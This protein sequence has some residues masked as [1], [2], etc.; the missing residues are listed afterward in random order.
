MLLPRGYV[1]GLTRR[2]LFLGATTLAATFVPL[3]VPA[4]SSEPS[5]E[6]AQVRQGLHLSELPVHDPFVVAHEPT[7]TYWLYTSASPRET[8]ERRFGVMAYTSRD[9]VEWEGPHVVFEI[10]DGTWANPMHGAWA[11]EVHEYEGRFHLFVTLHNNDSIFAEPP[12]V[13][14]PNHLRGSVVAVAD[15]PGGPFELLKPEGPHP[16][17]HFMTLD[18]SLYVDPEGQPW[19]V[20]C[21]EWIQK[22]DGTIEAIRLTPDLSATVGEPIHLFKGSD[23]PWLNAAI[24]PNTDQLSYVT[25]GNQ[26]YRTKTGELL[27]LWS[28]YENGSYVETVARSESGRLEGPWVQL[29]PLVYQDSG[30]GMLFETFN[31]QLMMVLHRPFGYPESRAL[32]FEMEDTGDNLR[33]V[34]PRPDLHDPVAHTQQSPR[35]RLDFDDDWRF[36]LGDVAAASSPSYDDSD[37][38]T[39]DLPHDW[40]IEGPFSADHASGTGYL[41]GGVGWYRKTFTLPESAD[42]KHVA[43]QFDGVYQ[44]AEVWINGHRLGKRPY[45]YISF[46]HELTPHLRFGPDAS[47]VIAV[48]VD[49]SQVA[50]SRWYNGS[51]IYRHVWLDVTDAVRVA[52]WGTY[53]TTPEVHDDRARVRIET[54]LVNGTDDPREVV[55]ESIVLDPDGAVVGTTESTLTLAARGTRTASQ[56]LDLDGPRLWSVEQ[57]QLYTLE[58]HVRG[59][60]GQALDRYETPFGIRTVRFDPQQGFFLNG[61][62]MLIKGVCLHHD[63]GPLGAAVPVAEWEHRLE[64]MKEMGA[65]AIRTSHNPAAPELLDLADRMGFLVMEEA[66][67][68]FEHGKKKWIQGWNV[69]QDQGRAGEGTYYATHGYSDFFEEWAERDLRDMVRRDRNHASIVLW[70]IGNEVDYPNDPY[71]DPADEFYEEGRPSFDE[72]PGLVQMLYDVVKSVDPTRPVTMASAN[73]PVANEHG[74]ADILDVTGYNYQEDHYEEDH[75]RYPERAIIGSEN[76]D[77]YQAW[78]VVEDNPYVAGQFLWTGIDYLGEAGRFPARSNASGLVDLSTFRKPSFY[79]RKSLWSDEPVVHLAVVDPTDGG[80]RPGVASH[81]SWDVGDGEPVSVLAYSNVDSV[82]LSLD[83]QPLG[84]R[85]R[86][87]AEEGVLRWEVGYAPG[88]LRAVGYRDGEAVA[89]HSL[90][91]AR[92]PTR[93]VLDTDRQSLAADGDDVAHVRAYVVDAEGRVV[94]SAD[95]VIRFDV[96]GP[97]KNIGVG[98]GDHRSTESFQADRR[99]AL[100]GRALLFVQSTEEPGTIHVRASAEGLEG[101]E[102]TISNGRP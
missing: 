32:L 72:L 100:Q 31:G 51:G 6:P 59:D 67:D 7:G 11:P 96:S 98:S 69:G 79:F 86:A 90:A 65:N 52:Q 101:A 39:L 27:M 93:L 4:Q 20:Y 75:A 1:R 60:E 50:D 41:P 70:S 55:I 17:R 18:G 26:L 29:D 97:G 21:H 28:A 56:E 34:R 99:R 92:A 53:V 19:M 12:E 45:G 30:H 46:Y 85:T 36:H 76:N 94:P 77:A 13:W 78:R 40:S 2:R 35:E 24:T 73:I 58:T 89:S 84:T 15:A 37:W 63:A 10:P 91:T 82:S 66:F 49:H 43:I 88:T 62:H 14:R 48:R 102:L 33:V 74:Y 25:D 16:P 83:G 95:P 5:G 8:G 81:W 9:L 87:D 22:I 80:R 54:D 47:N 3:H 44:N 61:E 23:A 38:R 64:L 42:G 68:E 71:G 57:P